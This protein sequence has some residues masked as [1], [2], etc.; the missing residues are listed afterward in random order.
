MPTFTLGDLVSR[1][2]AR[3]DNNSQLYTTPEITAVINEAQV[4]SNIL[5]GYYQGPVVMP[6]WSQAGARWYNTPP[7]MLI[8]SK[9]QWEGRYLQPTGINALGRSHRTWSTD[10][11]ANTGYP[12]SGW[13]RWGLNK[14]AVWPADSL[15]GAQ[16]VVSGI[17]E[18]VPLVNPTDTV[19]WSSDV[20]NCFDVYTAHVLQMKESDAI[21][22][23]ATGD[24]S[25]WRG[26][27]K[28]LTWIQGMKQP[29]WSDQGRQTIG[30]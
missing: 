27:I 21:F 24:F 26:M 28:R 7:G 13:V 2:L 20:V 30:R 16:I 23:Q 11:T 12:V 6:G 1:V 19:T 25:A 9:I 15:G 14:F 8:P 3:L 17:L 5:I 18:P 29:R 4:V 22:R 10:T